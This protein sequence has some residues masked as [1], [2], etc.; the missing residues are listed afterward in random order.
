LEVVLQ[1]SREKKRIEEATIR[2]NMERAVREAT[3]KARE[4]ADRELKQKAERIEG[5]IK[6][7]R[8]NGCCTIS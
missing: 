8:E 5:A 6:R 2:N 7:L 3:K 1:D 4:E